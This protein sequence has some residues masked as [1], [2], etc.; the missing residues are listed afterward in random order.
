MPNQTSCANSDSSDRFTKAE[1]ELLQEFSW[2]NWFMD[3]YWPENSPRVRLMMGL[4]TERWQPGHRAI[5]VGCAN[6]YIAFLLNELGYQVDAVDAYHDP[7]RDKIFAKKGI[8]YWET[9]LND[10]EP[11]AKIPT[12]SY[13]LLLLGEVFEHI[14]NQ[15]TGLLRNCLRV[16]RPGG[17]MI[18]TT[19]NPST[20]MTAIRVLKDEYVLWGTDEFLRETK[21]DGGSVIDNGDIHYREYPAR[22]VVGLM[23]ELGFKIG[24]VRYVQMGVAKI[25]SPVKRLFKRLLQATPLASS[26]LFSPGY[27]I[28]AYKDGTP[29]SGSDSRPEPAAVTA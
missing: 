12:G 9:N 29:S 4:A 11:L 23:A 2:N 17:M 25:H 19:P 18:L 1:R 16:L 13:D 15:P 24:G 5:E 26:R 14:L 28:W 8:R 10:V 7:D 3:G 20:V 22:L 21:V 6:G 27:V